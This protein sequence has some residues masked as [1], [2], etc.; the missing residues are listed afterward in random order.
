MMGPGYLFGQKVEQQHWRWHPDLPNNERAKQVWILIREEQIHTADATI[1]QDI[2]MRGEMNT[3]SDAMAT[4]TKDAFNN[5]EQAMTNVSQP[6]GAAQHGHPTMQLGNQHSM[7][8]AP[9]PFPPPCKLL[10]QT[11]RWEW[12]RRSERSSLCTQNPR[13]G[14]GQA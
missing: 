14:E 11:K 6:L 5:A 9:V 4:S 2:N 3:S 8:V 10:R 13:C 12:A 7:P 1:K